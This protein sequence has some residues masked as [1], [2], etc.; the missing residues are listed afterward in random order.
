MHLRLQRLRRAGGEPRSAERQ[1]A[2]AGRE[3]R[4]QTGAGGD[5]IRLSVLRCGA[6]RRHGHQRQDHH[7]TAHRPHPSQRAHPVARGRQRR[8][9]V[10]LRGG[11]A[12]RDG[13]R[14]HRGVEFPAGRGDEVRSRHRGHA[15]H[16]PRP[17]GQTREYAKVHR[18]K[19]GHIPAAV[20]ERRRGLQ[21][22]RRKRALSPSRRSRSQ[23]AVQ[24]VSPRGRRLSFLGVRVLEGDARGG[25]RGHGFLRQ[26]ARRRAC[27]RCRRRRKERG[28]LHRGVR[29]RVLFPSGVQARRLRRGGRSEDL[30]RQQSHQRARHR[31]RRGRYA[32]GHRAHLGRRGQGRGLRRSVR[33][34]FPVAESPDLFD[35]CADALDMAKELGCSNVLFSPSSKSYDRFTGFVERGR[36]FDAAVARLMRTR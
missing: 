7:D 28:S 32:R 22:R 2:C 12:G 25:S 21:R 3:T 17:S 8:S 10:F 13:D 29:P 35:A 34:G 30:Q 15:Q 26:R 31:F 27:R 24:R 20:G 33:G 23:S 5:G 4:R 19:G 9:G 6:D 1:S 14:R 16:H 36:A 18:R 11:Q